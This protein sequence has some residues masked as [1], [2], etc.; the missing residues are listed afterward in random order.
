MVGGRMVTSASM[1][2]RLGTML[3]ILALSASARA[4]IWSW[5][6]ADGG[7]HYTNIPPKKSARWKKVM[8]EQPQRGSKAAAHRGAC[9]RCDVVP[10]TDNSPE[11]FHRYDA[12]I[13]EAS[14]LYHI[15]V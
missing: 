9:A 11:R 7:V 10:A 4:D 3:L 2:A 13:A 12:Y 8:V 15:P 6:D 1:R 14:A 5:T